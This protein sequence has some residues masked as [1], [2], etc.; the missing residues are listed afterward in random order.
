[1]ET[2][3]LLDH[4]TG[5]SSTL[6]QLVSTKLHTS[7]KCSESGVGHSQSLHRQH[8]HSTHHQHSQ[9]KMARSTLKQHKSNSEFEANS[10]NDLSDH[11]LTLRP[12]ATF[13]DLNQPITNIPSTFQGTQKTA[14]ATQ[15]LVRAHPPSNNLSSLM[16]SN[17]H[18]TV[19][20]VVQTTKSSEFSNTSVESLVSFFYI[21]GN[22]VTINV[23]L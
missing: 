1:M 22:N 9:E 13:S 16:S 14:H 7:S 18:G 6:H 5:A 17:Q 21:R 15:Q 4:Y 19:A 23:Y 12:P 3:P 20:E 8:A 10:G 2:V 11:Q